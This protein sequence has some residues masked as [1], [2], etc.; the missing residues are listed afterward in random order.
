[1]KI[2]TE[3]EAKFPGGSKNIRSMH[4]KTE[5]SM[6]LPIFVSDGNG[7]ASIFTPSSYILGFF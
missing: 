4:L 7:L 5:T 3:L 2:M 6:A 1:M